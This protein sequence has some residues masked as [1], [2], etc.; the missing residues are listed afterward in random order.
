LHHFTIVPSDIV[1]DSDGIFT[2]VPGVDPPVGFEVS[3]AA[4]SPDASELLLASTAAPV[5]AEALMLCQSSPSS[6]RTAIKVPTCQQK[7]FYE[8]KLQTLFNCLKVKL[9]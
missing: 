8:I 6:A 7:Q 5:G 2:S 4:T 1:G 9:S 3:S